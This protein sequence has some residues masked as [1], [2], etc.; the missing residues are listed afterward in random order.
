MYVCLCHGIRDR[1]LQQAV[2]QGASSF[3]ELQ[4]RTGVASCCRTCEPT[5]RE[6]LDTA[7]ASRRPAI[8]AA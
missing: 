6:L 1:E 2:D 5:A 3:E 7:L 4:A 8:Q